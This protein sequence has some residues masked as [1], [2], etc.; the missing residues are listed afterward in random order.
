MSCSFNAFNLLYQ[1]L[2]HCVRRIRIEFDA[3]A[4]PE[5]VGQVVQ[6]SPG[7]DRHQ[8]RLC[9]F[10]DGEFGDPDG[11]RDRLDQSAEIE[12]ADNDRAPA[13]VLPEE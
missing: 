10:V 2:K 13:R 5:I 9:L 1:C 6:L 3:D 4:G 12:C 8:Q 7:G 11:V